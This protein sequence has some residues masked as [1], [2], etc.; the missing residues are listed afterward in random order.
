[1]AFN[2]KN[3]ATIQ[4]IPMPKAIDDTTPGRL[5]RTFAPEIEIQLK[6]KK[7]DQTTNTAQVAG[8]TT[9]IGYDRSFT[10]ALTTNSP[11]ENEELGSFMSRNSKDMFL[12][13]FK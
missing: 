7:M 9:A 11:S 8:G 1:M 5:K 13:F 6:I 4:G 2:Q 10:I 3:L 12:T